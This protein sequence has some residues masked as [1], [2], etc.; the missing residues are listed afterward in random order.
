MTILE[1]RTRV[2]EVPGAVRR[3][4]LDSFPEMKIAFALQM[5]PLGP[6]KA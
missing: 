6:R 5:F 3:G 1:L 2:I 4:R